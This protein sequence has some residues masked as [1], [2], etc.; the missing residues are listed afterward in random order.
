MKAILSWSGN[1]VYVPMVHAGVL[2]EWRRDSTGNPIAGV[3]VPSIE[4]GRRF[5]AVKEMFWPIAE[6]K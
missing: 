2:V 4:N 5:A 6:E 3:Y 1:G